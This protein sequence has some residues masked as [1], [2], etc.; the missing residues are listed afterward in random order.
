MQTNGS[1]FCY[2]SVIEKF[3]FEFRDVE[4]NGLTVL[5][6]LEAIKVTLIKCASPSLISITSLCSG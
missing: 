4:K 5:T 3:V 1:L 2:F 6:K